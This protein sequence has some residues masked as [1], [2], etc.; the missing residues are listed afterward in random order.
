MEKYIINNRT[1][2]QHTSRQTNTRQHKH[3][4]HFCH[5]CLF[6]AAIKL[7]LWQVDWE[8]QWLV[9]R[10]A[11]DGRTALHKSTKWRSC[12][13]LWLITSRPPTATHLSWR[14]WQSQLKV[15]PGVHLKHNLEIIE[16]HEQDGL[17]NA[18]I[19]S[20]VRF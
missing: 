11:L 4:A 16:K 20:N 5:C 12:E 9:L 14:S 2:Q 15:M 10:W 17:T 8:C 7:Y 18:I 19:L 1:E 13:G 6:W 3:F